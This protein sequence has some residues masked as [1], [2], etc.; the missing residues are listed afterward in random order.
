M[1][2]PVEYQIGVEA[3]RL[4]ADSPRRAAVVGGNHV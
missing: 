4:A 2:I 1:P 3:V